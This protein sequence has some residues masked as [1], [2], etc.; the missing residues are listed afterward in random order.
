MQATRRQMI[1]L[2]AL[3]LAGCGGGVTSPPPQ[4][5][6][7]PA[8][9]PAAE[10]ATYRLT[11][12]KLWLPE[13]FPTQF[14][15]SAHLTG[16]VGA[17]HGAGVDFW[18][19]G[20]L[21]SLG[22]KDVAERGDKIAMLGEV[23]RA[24]AAGTAAAAI[25]GPAIARDASELSIEIAVSRAH[26][27]L[28]LLT[29]L[30]PSPDWFTGVAGVALLREGAWI[31]RLDMDLRAYDAGTDDGASFLAPDAVSAPPLPVARLSTPAQ[32]SDFVDGL[33][34]ITGSPIATLTLER[35]G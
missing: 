24:I 35:T 7:S 15:P 6:P 27:R 5:E 20:R 13:H 12:R 34:R 11:L 26:A 1:G 3:M 21:A 16:I 9:S 33:S 4:A 29:M 31:A 17:T 14:P 22:V 19:P 25:D 32:D 10:A 18:A 30:G 23:A 2:A 8:P 28:T